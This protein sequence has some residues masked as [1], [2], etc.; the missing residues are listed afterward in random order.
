MSS[1]KKELGLAQAMWV[2]EVKHFG[3]FLVECDAGGNS[4]FERGN[5]ENNKKFLPLFERIAS[6]GLEAAG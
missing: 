6:A 5:E 2:L 1:W 4:L 3:P